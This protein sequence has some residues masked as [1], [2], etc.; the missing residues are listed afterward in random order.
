MVFG[1]T[2]RDKG[3]K[4]VVLVAKDYVAANVPRG[5]NWLRSWCGIVEKARADDDKEELKEKED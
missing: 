5:S 3:K 4:Q 2:R 1:W